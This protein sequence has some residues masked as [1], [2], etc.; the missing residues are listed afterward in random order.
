MIEQH[1]L[2]WNWRSLVTLVL[3][4]GLFGVAGVGCH[5]KK[6]ESARFAS[7]EIHGS[8]P[9]Q[10]ADRILE[11]FRDDGYSLA[12]S[13]TDNF[14]FEKK[15]STLNNI[16]YGNWTETPVWV[17]VKVAAVP[18]HD[19]LTRIECH[20]FLLRD[21]GA[22]TEEEIAVSSLRSHP[23]Q[24]LLNEVALR[25]SPHPSLDSKAPPPASKS[26]AQ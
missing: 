18:V 16:A 3:T 1:R 6:P 15:A 14:V 8:S 10:I 9:T 26:A 24:K 12:Q 17:R 19:D 4:L 13:D 2:G 21:H 23:Y 22:N 5:S 20:A 25:L 11:V 7:V